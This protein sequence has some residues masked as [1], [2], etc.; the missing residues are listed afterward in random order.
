M[1]LD[2]L[3]TMAGAMRLYESLGFKRC[4]AYYAN[5]MQTAVYFVKEL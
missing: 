2:T 1:F 5:P 4:A 3:S